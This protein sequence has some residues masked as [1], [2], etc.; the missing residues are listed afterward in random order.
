MPSSASGLRLAA[1]TASGSGTPAATTFR[2]AVSSAMTDP[3]RVVVPAR[4]TRLSDDLDVEAADPA[5][6]RRPMPGQRYERR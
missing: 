2:T 4:V 6:A 1:A 5:R 3:A